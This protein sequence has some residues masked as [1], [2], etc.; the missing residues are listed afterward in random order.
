M[1]EPS[2][3]DADSERPPGWTALHASTAGGRLY[4]AVWREF[5]DMT[6]LELDCA[7]APPPGIA[8][9]EPVDAVARIRAMREARTRRLDLADDQWQRLVH[10][11]W[12]N[13]TEAQRLSAQ[14]ILAE[15]E[16]THPQPRQRPPADG[17][18]WAPAQRKPGPELIV[19]RQEVEDCR[20]EL[21]AMGKPH[22]HQ[23]VARA[24][25][26]SRTTVRRCLSGH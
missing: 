25:G 21:I 18:K 5:P 13:L 20:A 8:W 22:G 26:V 4:V 7:I 17:A 24:L 12:P 6:Q 2:P 15:L 9:L 14:E 11:A 23:A 1:S 19:G 16:L 3:G 10:R